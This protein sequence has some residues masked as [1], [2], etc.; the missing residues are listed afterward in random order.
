MT[1]LERIQSQPTVFLLGA[2]VWIPITIWV[3]AMV[4]WAVSGDV[5]GFVA[6][7]SIMLALTMGYFSINPP[8]PWVSPVLATSIFGTVICFP[9]LRSAVVRRELDQIEFEQVSKAY[10]NL[11]SSP[12]STGLKLK[13]AKYMFDRGLVHQA[14]AIGETSLVG[15]PKSA[16]GEEIR[17]VNTWKMMVRPPADDPRVACFRCR[18]VNPLDACFCER[19]GAPYLLEHARGG[20]ISASL[21]RRVLASWIAGATVLVALPV[22]ASSLPPLLALACVVIEIGIAAWIML[23]AFRQGAQT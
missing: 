5:P 18:F 21:G 9:F 8:K 2:L 22:T 15:A 7:V 23:R 14:L 17:M 1:M 13:L 3:V 6:L 10:A 11:A 4:H 20:W 16:F 19:C 12:N